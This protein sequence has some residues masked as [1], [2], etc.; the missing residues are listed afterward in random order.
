MKD[1]KFVYAYDSKGEKLI[2]AW[3]HADNMLRN[4]IQ[5]KNK[6]RKKCCCEEHTRTIMLI[7]D[8]GE[9]NLITYCM[10][11]FRIQGDE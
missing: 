8:E 2:S 11:C 10:K 3:C 1:K 7:D 5:S 9:D 4:Y 6:N